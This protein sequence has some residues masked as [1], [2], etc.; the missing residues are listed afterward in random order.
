M[1]GLELRIKNESATQPQAVQL[2]ASSWWLPAGR[3]MVGRQSPATIVVQA[4]AVSREHAFFEVELGGC[5]PTT[6]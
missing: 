6:R 2:Q 3:H 1:W 5:P 4:K